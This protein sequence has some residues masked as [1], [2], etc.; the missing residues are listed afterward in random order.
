MA[1]EISHSKSDNQNKCSG[2]NVVSQVPGAADDDTRKSVNIPRPYLTSNVIFVV[3]YLYLLFPIDAN[4]LM[5]LT[6]LA[7]FQAINFLGR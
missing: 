3:S 1:D 5:T 7:A 4:D 2:E 6:N